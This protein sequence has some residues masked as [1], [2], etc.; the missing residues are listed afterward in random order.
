MRFTRNRS[1]RWKAQFVRSYALGLGL[2]VAASGAGCAK[3]VEPKPPEIL[4]PKPAADLAVRQLSDS[5]VLTFSNPTQNT[6]G[7][8][9]TTLKTVEVFRLTEDA[10]TAGSARPLSEEQFLKQAVSVL[11]LPSSA[12]SG[13]LRGTAFVI[14]D[15]FQ[16]PP[17]AI[18][19]HTFRYAVRFMNNK[20]RTAGLSNQMRIAPIPIPGPPEGIVAKVSQ[21][22]V[23]L[24]WIAPVENM[25]ASKP[26]R[27]VG[28]NIYRSEEPDSLPPAPMNHDPVQKP[29][30]EDRSFQ[31][32]KTYYY[33]VST[34]GSVQNPHAESIPSKPRQ[35]VT[36]DVFPP[37]PPGDLSAILE[38]GNV[39]LLW[40]PSPS[41]DVAGYRLYRQEKGT[42]A[43]QLVQKELIKGLS[44]RDTAA[45]PGKS[46]EYSIQA[47]DTHG[48]E[49]TVV[50]TE[51]EI[52]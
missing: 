2:L 15:K 11:S 9:A 12:F 8:P 38:G 47:V 40:T 13:Y 43:R 29:E 21:D 52:R 48:N 3:I 28:Y 25:D 41:A 44:I 5:V 33:A 20:K 17:A 31:F 10:Q 42:A 49:S 34:I 45:E 4:L 30:F 26:P 37:A 35:V 1:G 16:S 6:N 50:Q 14:R 51:V 7:S 32:D 19:S 27:I 23:T 22:A 46:Y 18:Y 24:N 39:L 36:L